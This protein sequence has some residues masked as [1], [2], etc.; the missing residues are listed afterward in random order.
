MALGRV[1]QI[2][3][4]S[5]FRTSL[6]LLKLNDTASEIMCHLYVTNGL[7]KLHFCMDL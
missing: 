4:L 6:Q 5:S 1:S 3:V 7:T 2:T